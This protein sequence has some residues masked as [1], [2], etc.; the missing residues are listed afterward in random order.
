MLRMS[1]RKQDY[2]NAL[3]PEITKGL[4]IVEEW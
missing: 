2:M 4:S 1:L 3:G